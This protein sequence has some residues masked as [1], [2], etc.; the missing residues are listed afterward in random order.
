MKRSV[1]RDLENDVE[2]EAIERY[3]KVGNCFAHAHCYILS[4]VANSPENFAPRGTGNGGE[5]NFLPGEFPGV[6]ENS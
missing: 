6:S 4:R 2:C 3:L 5:Q 1:S